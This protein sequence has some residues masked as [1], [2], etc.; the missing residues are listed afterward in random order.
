M[1]E[2]EKELLKVKLTDHVLAEVKK[3][4]FVFKRDDI[5]TYR[6]VIVW[7][8][9]IVLPV[10]GFSTY[11][12][13]AYAAAKSVAAWEANK[14]ASA[15]LKEAVRSAEASANTT[16][17]HEANAKQSASD[18]DVLWNQAKQRYNTMVGMNDVR[19]KEIWR[20]IDMLN[21]SQSKYVI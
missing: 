14:Q 1:T 4:Y 12:A 3:T 6:R 5:R 8:S 2:D 10:L 17:S 15:A 9:V 19:I 13:L 18:I 20:Q 7:V 11:G 16:A 21:A